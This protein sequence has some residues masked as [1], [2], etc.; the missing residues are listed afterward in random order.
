MNQPHINPKPTLNKHQ[1]TLTRPPRA[2]CHAGIHNNRF[3]GRKLK[4]V[5]SFE[6]LRHCRMP[7]HVAKT[8]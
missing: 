3:D 7:D 1:L 8:L 2:L 6:N 5:F 4:Q